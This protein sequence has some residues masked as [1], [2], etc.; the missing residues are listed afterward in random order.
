MPR[1]H[2][3]EADLV[4]ARELRA[5]RQVLGR[6]AQRREVRSAVPDDRL[7]PLRAQIGRPE[8][9][10]REAAADTETRVTSLPRHRVLEG[11]AALDRG[12]IVESTLHADHGAL[13]VLD[14]AVVDLVPDEAPYL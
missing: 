12:A 3:G 11:V 13:R 4:A 14:L 8:I 10:E 9:V 6:A 1:L 2:L 5:A 7:R